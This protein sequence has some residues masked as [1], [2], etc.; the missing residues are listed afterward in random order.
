[1]RAR[2][3]LGGLL[4]SVPAFSLPC[5]VALEAPGYGSATA[6]LYR[7]DDQVTGR[8]VLL[9]HHELDGAGR[10]SFTVDVA[11]ITMA[12][13]R[14]GTAYADLFLTP[15]ASYALRV[16][17]PDPTRPASLAGTTRMQPVFNALDPFDINALVGDLNRLIDGFVAEHL[18]TDEE[19]GMQAAER[20]RNAPKDS[21][22]RKGRPPTVF[23]LPSTDPQ[24][25]DSFEMKLR[26]SYADVK[27]PWFWHYLDHSVAS[28]RLGPQ[29]D[30]K[31]I[32]ARYIL[33]KP[34]H[35]DDPAQMRFLMEFYLGHLMVHVFRTRAEEV[36]AFVKA[37]HG[38]SVM[39][40][41]AQHPFLADDPRL[42]ELVMID[43][44]YR[45]YHGKR[46]DRKGI[47]AILAGVETGSPFPEH[48]RIAANMR[49]D[50]TAM[51]VGSTFPSLALRDLDS[52]VIRMDDRLQGP[53]CI[54]VTASWC[55][56]C[57]LEM[58]ALDRLHQEYGDHVRFIA[59]SIDTT[60]NAFA[61]L[62]RRHGGG[63]RLWLSAMDDVLFMDELRLRA[64]PAFFLLNDGVIAQAPAPLPS[65]GMAEI[66]F[67]LKASAEQERK[68]R[69]REE[70][71][72]PGER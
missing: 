5:Q 39:S 72:P 56:P 44:L 59:I 60:W 33:H 61:A 6:R 43:Q 36:E 17:S 30:M 55:S 65:Q 2:A 24:R 26:R 32:H 45:Q 49:W 50:L 53:V 54:A 4:L 3:I 58:E 8:L 63:E 66:M 31:A 46:F 62:A 28:L 41:L 67:A 23:V 35:Y 15:G 71:A 70:S 7:F 12:R 19:A 11:G 40:L 18:A 22:E 47:E 13:I 9:E 69:F 27:D 25:I 38:D 51:Q 68:A 21:L 20:M 14:L 48:R 29:A 1:M 42:R 57:E 16:P 10:A 64:V 52:V 34:I 37:A